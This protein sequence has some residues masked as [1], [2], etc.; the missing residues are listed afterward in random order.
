MAVKTTCR[1]C[2]AEILQTTADATDNRCMPCWKD[3]GRIERKEKAAKAY[4]E[5]RERLKRDKR[6]V[7]ELSKEPFDDPHTIVT[8]FTSLLYFDGLDQTTVDEI[9]GVLHSLKQVDAPKC[10]AAI[11]GLLDFIEAGCSPEGYFDP[12]LVEKFLISNDELGTH[13]KN[14]EVANEAESP[15]EQLEAK[16]AD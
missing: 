14:Y 12:E 2:G 8:Q 1:I 11:H 15:I 5:E 9:L 7:R 10:E 13:E 3:P 6:I 4:A 16:F